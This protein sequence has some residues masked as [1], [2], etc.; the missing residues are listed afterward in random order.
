MEEKAKARRATI[1]LYVL[2]AVGIILP[3]LV[4]R[5]KR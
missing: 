2:M 5:L 3:F 1:I 4:L